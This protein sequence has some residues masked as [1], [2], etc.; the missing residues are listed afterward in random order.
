[1]K[2][3]LL[4]L[5][6]ILLSQVVFGQTDYKTYANARYGYSISYPADLLEP[7]GES[8]NGDGQVFK[9]SDA[10]MRVYGSN[11]VLGETLEKQYWKLLKNYGKSI[12]YKT[13]REKF[14]VVSAIRND[15]IFYQ[16]TFENSDGVFITFEIEYKKSERAKYDKVVTKI[17][18]SFKI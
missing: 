15:K 12:A 5:T 11:S 6:V 14:F 2:I 3:F 9:N 16:K 8:D 10:E 1:M 4:L 7:Q 18:K 13:F 17:V